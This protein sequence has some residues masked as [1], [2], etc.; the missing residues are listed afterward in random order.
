MIPSKTS[1]ELP[2]SHCMHP[3][4]PRREQMPCVPSSSFHGF[5]PAVTRGTHRR[6]V[7]LGERQ[8][9]TVAQW[10]HVVNLQGRR[11]PVAVLTEWIAT[12]RVPSLEPGAVALP[13]CRAAD[14][15]G[16]T[17]RRVGPSPPVI[18]RCRLSSVL[19]T[20]PP[21]HQRPASRFTAWSS[22][23]GPPRRSSIRRR[24]AGGKHLPNYMRGVTT[25]R[26][27]INRIFR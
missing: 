3:L 2:R 14:A 15:C 12:E 9:R 27:E 20:V 26:C 13:A 6:R 23:H 10:F 11:E 8:L 18:P 19:F 4:T 21:I 5:D 25:H 24:L 16:L 7:G 17:K 1:V 22:W